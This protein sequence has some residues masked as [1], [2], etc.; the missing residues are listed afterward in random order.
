[1]ERIYETRDRE[2]TREQRRIVKPGKVIVTA[3][4]RD[5]RLPNPRPFYSLSFYPL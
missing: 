1:M 5:F 3:S 4:A 2:I